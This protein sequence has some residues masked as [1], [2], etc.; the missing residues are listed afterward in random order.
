MDASDPGDASY[1][2]DCGNAQFEP[3]S[4]H[5]TQVA[6]I[7]GAATDNH[8]GIAGVGRDIMVLPVR[9][10]GRCGGTDSDIIAGMRWAAGLTSDVGGISPVINRHPAKVLNLSLGGSGLCTETEAPQYRE[11]MLELA[12]A[13]VTVVVAAG[14]EAGLAVGLPANCPGALAVS[15]LRHIGT[16]VG[17]SSIGAEVWISA[18]GGNCV[19]ET[20]PCLYPS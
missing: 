2:G 9:V 16:K 19:N 7:V 6:G 5:G 1:P 20:G 12:A 13:G 14:N 18:P 15:G 10:L 17:F 11:V 4:W 8:L 3:S